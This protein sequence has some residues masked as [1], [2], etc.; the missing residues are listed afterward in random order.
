MTVPKAK[1]LV[2]DDDSNLLELLVDTLTAIDYQAVAAPGGIEALDLLQHDSFD[3]IITDIRMPD[4][5]GLQLL[6]RVRRH[7]PNTPVLFITGVESPEIIGRAMPDG[8]LAKPFRI[9]Q[10]EQLIESTLKDKEGEFHPGMRR[11]LL[12]DRDVELHN[13]LTDTLSYSQYVPFSVEDAQRALIEL[14]NGSFDAVI[15]GL[16]VH[17]PQLSD[18]VDRVKGLYPDLPLVVAGPA[19]NRAA[20]EAWPDFHR[21]DGFLEKPFTAGDLIAMIESVGSDIPHNPT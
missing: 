1:I 5:D 21:V 13:M 2:V 10:L 14:E 17:D 15:A 19:G 12:V 7:H 11:V 8:F 3:L 20:T 6:K 16:D 9:S 18:L 4:V